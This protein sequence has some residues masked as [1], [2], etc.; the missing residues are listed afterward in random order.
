MVILFKMKEFFWITNRTQ[1]PTGIKPLSVVI[2]NFDGVHLG[3]QK[4]IEASVDWAKEHQGSSMVLTFHP[5]PLTVLHPEKMHTR[6]FDLEDQKKQIK[7]A[8]ANGVFLQ[9][10]SREF[11]EFTSDMFLNDFLFKSFQPDQIVVG[12]D[13]SFGKGRSGTQEMLKKFC[14][15]HKIHLKIVQPFTIQG[16]K[17]STSAVRHALQ[18]GE[19]KKAEKFLG[20]PYYLK[21]IV[22]KGEQRGRLLGFPTANI[23]PV[24]DFFPKTGVYATVTRRKG[25]EY[26]SVTN[27]GLNRTFVDGDFQPIKVETFLFDFNENLYGEEIEVV[28]KHY[29][30][31]EK[32]FPSFEDLKNQI[33]VD[34]EQARQLLKG[35]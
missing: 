16:E 19:L 25:I 28:L 10:F 4:L 31:E 13:F 27:I 12:F 8:G 26:P 23:K 18:S 29:L 15:Q 11:S 2:G 21:G 14:D 5:H 7:A 33:A 32:K 17:V 6:I 1:L 35:S 9:P 34:S 24:V 22:I 3:H 30:R 20:R